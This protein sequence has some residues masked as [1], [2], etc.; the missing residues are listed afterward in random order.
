EIRAEREA[1]SEQKSRL[2]ADVSALQTA[3][4]IR[5][6]ELHN[7]DIRADGLER[8][9]LDG[10]M[11]QSRVLMLTKESKPP[12]SSPRKL[13]DISHASQSTVGPLPPS[14]PASKGIN[15]A[16]RQRPPPIRRNGLN[17][18]ANSA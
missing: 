5:R 15:L 14:N 13:R 18:N 11:N 2:A 10:I 17:A 8:R 1:L 3:L 16:L 7:M 9:I 4:D 12:A 6:E